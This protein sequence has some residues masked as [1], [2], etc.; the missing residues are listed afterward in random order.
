MQQKK[1]V[2]PPQV[3]SRKEINGEN[4]NKREPSHPEGGSDSSSKG[5][6]DSLEEIDWSGFAG[7]VGGT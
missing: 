2:E 4:K 6:S 7:V 3:E 5:G 1:T